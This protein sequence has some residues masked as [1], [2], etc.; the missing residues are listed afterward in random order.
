MRSRTCFRTSTSPLAVLLVPDAFIPA[1]SVPLS[2]V[3][4]LLAVV[5]Y[6]VDRLPLIE[7]VSCTVKLS[8]DVVAVSLI[9]IVPESIRNLRLAR[10][11]FTM[12]PLRGW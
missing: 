7:W 11:G 8:N 4:T 2:L 5:T 12:P 3:S 6:E 9:V 10:P 1:E